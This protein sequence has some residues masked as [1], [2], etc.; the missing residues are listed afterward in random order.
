MPIFA[1]FKSILD[2]CWRERAVA[3]KFGVIPLAINLALVV[4]FAEAATPSFASYATNIAI[5]LISILAFA[6][7][8]VAWYRMVLVGKSDI[9]LRSIFTLTG[10]EFRFFGWTLS[11]SALAAIVSL[12]ALLVGGGIVV[13]L[14]ALNTYLGA[15]A[16]VALVLAWVVIL[17]MMLSRWSM[18]LAMAAAGSPTNLK[19]AWSISESYGWSMAWVQMLIFAVVGVLA[20]ICLAPFIPALAEASSA[21]VDPPAS[22]LLALNVVS[23]VFGA[24]S[25][26]LGST[27]FALVYRR[28]TLDDG[29]V[30]NHS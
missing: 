6:P 13:G 19:Y 14:S 9:E 27:L 25:L 29:T 30:P 4:V 8:C 24:V 2:L 5:A 10:R 17:L 3:L 28:I 16:G 7:F 15:V 20:A 12:I 21:K 1:T 22:A 18:T 11:I 23:T 26:W